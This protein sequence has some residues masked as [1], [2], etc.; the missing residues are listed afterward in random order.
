MEGNAE[1]PCLTSAP[2][3]PQY[4]KEYLT[5]NKL[6]S[7]KRFATSLTPGVH[8]DVCEEHLTT[9]VEIIDDYVESHGPSVCVKEANEL[10]NGNTDDISIQDN[11]M[12]AVQNKSGRKIMSEESEAFFWD[13]ILKKD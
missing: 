5:R 13:W 1:K 9:D 3:L 7:E 11:I 6:K 12:K 8:L 4:P 10:A 2:N